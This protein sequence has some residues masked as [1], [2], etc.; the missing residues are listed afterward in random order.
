MWLGIPR[1]MIPYP[2]LGKGQCELLDHTE[3][4]YPTVRGASQKVVGLSR[5]RGGGSPTPPTTHK[6]VEHPSGSGPVWEQAPWTGAS[7]KQ[8]ESPVVPRGTSNLRPPSPFH[9]EGVDGPSHDEVR[10]RVSLVQ[11]TAQVQE[12]LP[13]SYCRSPWFPGR[14]ACGTVVG[15]VRPAAAGTGPTSLGARPNCNSHS[16]PGLDA[17]VVL[18]VAI[19]TR[20]PLHQVMLHRLQ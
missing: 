2:V 5:R 7:S 18:M 13:P 10:P 19:A 3:A 20:Q 8:V 16:L 17:F 15:G 4:A 1:P 14:T 6:M 9:M 11:S 12:A